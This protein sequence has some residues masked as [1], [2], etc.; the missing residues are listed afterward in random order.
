MAYENSIGFVPT[1]K[2]RNDGLLNRP[3]FAVGTRMR[4]R[5]GRDFVFASAT[6]AVANNAA[7]VLTEPAMTVATGA[8]GWTNRTGLALVSGDFAWFEKNAI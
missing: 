8:G 3:P 4:G 2:Y 7:V 1:E 6:G 5:N